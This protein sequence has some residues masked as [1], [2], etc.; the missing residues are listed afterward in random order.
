MPT[1]DEVAQLR[2][3]LCHMNSVLRL[4]GQTR[5]SAW[6]DLLMARRRPTRGQATQRP[7]GGVSP[8]ERREQKDGRP[9]W[10]R[11]VPGAS[12]RKPYVCPWCEDRIP[13]GEPHLVVWPADERDGLTARRHWHTR[14][15]GRSP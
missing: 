8:Q 3:C 9:Y 7:L 1:G 2:D 12:A 5:G 13:I 14:C 6:L 11:M 4:T 15:W 10:V